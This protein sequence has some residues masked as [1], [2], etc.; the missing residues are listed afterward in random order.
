LHLAALHDI[1][2]HS[3]AGTTQAKTGANTKTGARAA[4]RAQAQTHRMM[5]RICS[6]P[7]PRNTESS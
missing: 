5:I 1:L 4:D 3:A 6:Q 7:R 2:E